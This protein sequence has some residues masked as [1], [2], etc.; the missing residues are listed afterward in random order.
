MNWKEITVNVKYEFARNKERWKSRLLMDIPSDLPVVPAQDCC[1]FIPD[2]PALF[3]CGRPGGGRDIA[4]FGTPQTS[5]VK[6]V[7]V[8]PVF[9][10]ALHGLFILGVV[11]MLCGLAGHEELSFVGLDL[12]RV[13]R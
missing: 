13:S 4:P 9:S 5:E 11:V 2:H 10:P 6:L 3:C 8:K 7:G 12:V 1:L